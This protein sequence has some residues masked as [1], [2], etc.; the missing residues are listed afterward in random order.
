MRRI[1]TCSW[2]V[3]VSSRPAQH[4][5]VERP[6]DLD[7]AGAGRRI[8]RGEWMADVVR[9]DDAAFLHQ[10]LGRGQ[11]ALTVLVVDER[12]PAVVRRH[13]LLAPAG[14]VRGEDLTNS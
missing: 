14:E 7:Q 8:E 12:Q 10:R 11:T 2:A 9:G 3:S 6:G 1:S 4:E 13:R 5:R